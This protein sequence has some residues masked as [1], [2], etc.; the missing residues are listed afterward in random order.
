MWVYY[1][2][3][4]FSMDLSHGLTLYILLYSLAMGLISFV[5][6]CIMPLI[7]SYV[8][9]ITGISYD[10]LVSPDSRRKN[11]NITLFHSLAFVAGF[12]IIFVL[13]GASASLAGNLL[14]R[15]LNTIRIVGGVLIIIMGVFVMDV[16]NIPFLQREAKLHLKTRPAGY[17]GTLVVGMIFGAGWTPCTGPF[18]GSVL[19]LAMTS[20]T[21]GS[22][23]VLLMCYSL[24]LGIPFILSAIAI[25]AF[26]A[27]FS[28]LKKHLKAIRIVSGVVL[29]IMGVL[30][31]LD[32]MTILIPQ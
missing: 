27:S 29:I 5:S 14:A 9:Y 7:P 30:L 25:S 22:G 15:H 16:V 4:A 28:K 11:M 21:L 1:K 17:I 13:L 3:D 8:S 20:D 18:L 10:E 32:K 19:A 23:M 24:G 12:S 6:P 2:G 26:L 31:L